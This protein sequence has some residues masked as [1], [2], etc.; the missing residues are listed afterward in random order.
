MGFECGL[1]RSWGLFSHNH[2][3]IRGYLYGVHTQLVIG[4]GSI[5]CSQVWYESPTNLLDE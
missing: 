5:D 1:V 4:E 2:L 3:L